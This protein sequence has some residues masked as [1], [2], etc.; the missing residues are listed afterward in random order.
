[1]TKK[2]GIVQRVRSLFRPSDRNVWVTKHDDGWQ[3]R[4]EKKGA[5]LGTYATQKEAW[6]AARDTARADKVSA[7]LHATDGKIRETVGYQQA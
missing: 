7:V 1:M 6:D 5:V 4:R 2:P 3:V